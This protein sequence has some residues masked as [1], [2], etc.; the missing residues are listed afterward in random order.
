MK[1]NKC[2][3][4]NFSSTWPTN[5]R[6]HLKMHSGENLKRCKQCKQCH[7]TCSDPSALRRPLKTEKRQTKATSANFQNMDCIQ[8]IPANIFVL[9][10]H[11][12]TKMN[13]TWFQIRIRI[14]T[15][16]SSLNYLNSIQTKIQIP[17]Y[18][19]TSGPDSP[20]TVQT[21]QKLYRQSR[22]YPHNPETVWT[23]QKLSRQSKNRPDNP[24]T[25][26]II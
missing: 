15:L 7:Y 6:T 13:T 23:I 16:V 26:L 11:S 12:N 24:E 19:L 22:N 18:S 20:E 10:N 25:V 3:Q 4:C 17:N 8:K 14:Q 9:R 2:N 5:L 21:V 1:C